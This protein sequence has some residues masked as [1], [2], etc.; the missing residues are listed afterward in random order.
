MKVLSYRYQG[1]SGVGVVVGASASLPCRRPL[2]PLPDDLRKILEI[3]PTLATVRAATNG[4]TADHS[5]DDI[6]FEPVI[7]EPHATWALALN[8]KLHIE[9]TGLTTSQVYPQIFLRMPICQVG[10]KIRFGPPAKKL[11]RLTTMKVSSPSSSASLAL[12]QARAGVRPSCRL[13]LL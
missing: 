2:Q 3:D 13:L 7:R 10:H 11:P 4:K 8:Y 5:L 9:E 6:E 1:K 12:H